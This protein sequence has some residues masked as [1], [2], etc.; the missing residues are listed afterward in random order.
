MLRSR[1]IETACGL[2]ENDARELN[3]GFF[4]RMDRGRPWLRMKIAA[5]LDGRTA[6][7][8]GRSQWITGP[9]ARRDGH[10]WRA[11]ACTVLTGIGTVMEDDPQLT[12]RDVETSRQPARV[13]V[14]SRLDI[15][16]AA[17]VLGPGTVIAAARRDDSRIAALRDRGADVMV[18]PN[19]SGKVDLAA[20]MTELGARGMNEVH[21]EAGHK[22][23]GS[24]LRENL[25]DE[26]L[27]YL[28][29]QI[30]G[31]TARG[32][33][34]LPELTELSQRHEL[35]LRDVRPIGGDVRVLARVKGV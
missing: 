25:V 8:N 21:I 5:S 13:V 3:I 33:F 6:L 29:P 11:R 27:V 12:V 7:A 15:S 24:L 16:P 19:A 26:L 18:L 32:M 4:S 9:E 23:N 28:A 20:L 17:R 35:E 10:H 30:L 22:L 34:H 31:D 2:L 1:G 14:D